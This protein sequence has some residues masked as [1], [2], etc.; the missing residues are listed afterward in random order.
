MKINFKEL[1]EKL[2]TLTGN[3]LL[4]AERDCRAAGETF[5]TLNFS[6]A[7]Q[8]RLAA[9]ALNVNPHDIN[10]LPLK[11]FNRVCQIVFNFLFS[12][13]GSDESTT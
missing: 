4:T 8:A 11:E 10:D 7:F 9:R 12:A 13:Q 1:E 6:S 2:G 5:P 3:D